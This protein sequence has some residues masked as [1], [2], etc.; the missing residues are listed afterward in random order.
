M[1]TAMANAQ[2]LTENRL[3]IEADNGHREAQK[4]WIIQKSLF[5]IPV[6]FVL[7]IMFPEAWLIWLFF[8]AILMSL[9]CGESG[10][11]SK[12]RSGA[13]GED[14]TLNLLLSLP[15]SYTIFNQVNVPNKK[16]RT[17]NTEVDLLVVGPNGAFVIEV[18]NKSGCM[19]GSERDKM[20]NVHKFNKR[21]YWISSGTMENPIEQL[22]RQIWTLRKFTREQ[23]YKIWF[24]G[25][26]FLSNI[27][28]SINRIGDFSIPVLHYAGLT[29]YILNYKPKCPPRNLD[30]IT[31]DLVTIKQL[32]PSYSKPEAKSQGDNKLYAKS[33]SDDKFY[34]KLRN[35]LNSTHSESLWQPQWK[36]PH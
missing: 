15:D 17:G 5:G 30:K 33:W 35:K 14:M 3:T 36:K 16:S 12:K 34:E 7:F 28:S 32:T 26:V 11:V 18:K 31:Q 13:K 25:V 22:N 23:G 2:Y 8:G 20:W 29:D 21:G 9:P 1:K 10:S 24:D 6:S 19:E 27:E 4:D